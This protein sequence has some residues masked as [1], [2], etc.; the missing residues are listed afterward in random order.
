MNVILSG[1][2]HVPINRWTVTPYWSRCI[3]I[4]LASL[5]HFHLLISRM[6]QCNVNIV[7]IYSHL[8]NENVTNLSIY[9]HYLHSFV[10]HIPSFIFVYWDDEGTPFMTFVWR[11]LYPKGDN[12]SKDEGLLS[13]TIVLLCSWCIASE[14]KDQHEHWLGTGLH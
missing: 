2:H 5:S 13:L 7:N 12:A 10:F 11:S 6:Y 4:A 1:L 3:V 8:W 14:N 9:H